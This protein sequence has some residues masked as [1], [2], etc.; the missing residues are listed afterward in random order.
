MPLRASPAIRRAIA[1]EGATS[2][3]RQRGSSVSRGST[4]LDK[5][6]HMAVMQ[7]LYRLEYKDD[8]EAYNLRLKSL[9]DA[10]RALTSTRWEEATSLVML[11]YTGSSY[12][13]GTHLLAKSSLYRD[14]RDMLVVIDMERLEYSHIGLHDQSRLEV[15]MQLAKGRPLA[16][17]PVGIYGKATVAAALSAPR[18]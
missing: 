17:A 9:T 3:P 16:Q 18:T 13:L 8:P 6:P 7:V 2:S 11:Q 10:I 15:L 1:E 14:G 4:Q 12:D 5:G